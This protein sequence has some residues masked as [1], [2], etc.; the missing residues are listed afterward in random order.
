MK[1]PGLASVLLRDFVEGYMRQLVAVLFLLAVAACGRAQADDIAPA[2][3]STRPIADPS[4]SRGLDRPGA[5]EDP[6]DACLRELL[7]ADEPAERRRVQHRYKVSADD[8]HDLV[9]DALLNVCVSHS[10]RPYE[11]LAAALHRA[12]DNRARDDWRRRRRYL[13]CPVDDN[14]P[15]CQR[16]ADETVRFAQ[17]DRVIA[18]AVCR[19]DRVSERII[20]LRVIEEMAFEEIGA[21]FEPR[22][23]ADQ[24]R[25]MFHNAIRRI[26]EQVAA[27]CRW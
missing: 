8:A 7:A 1:L 20:R 2:P 5:V 11:R 24:A 15:T 13:S 25:T 12:V 22:L 14:M 10:R 19:V 27:T 6:F 23:T 16:T 3:S 26:R 17:E 21:G 9:R 4:R 18:A